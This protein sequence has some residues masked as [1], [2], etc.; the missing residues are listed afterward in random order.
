[1]QLFALEA[2]LL[3]FLEVGFCFG[4]A[5][6]CAI[7]RGAGS[8]PVVHCPQFSEPV[9]GRPDH[10]QDARPSRFRQAGPCLHYRQQVGVD[11]GPNRRL[12]TVVE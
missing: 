1:M 3:G 4:L 8:R 5:S 2:K 12:A 6:G 11:W 9:P 10:R 7:R